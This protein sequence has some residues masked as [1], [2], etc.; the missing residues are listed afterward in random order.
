MPTCP[1]LSRR[2]RGAVS[3]V[4]RRCRTTASPPA[5]R[6]SRNAADS[7]APAPRRAGESAAVSADLHAREAH[8]A[9]VAIF[10][11]L[12]SYWIISFCGPR[13]IRSKFL[14]PVIV[15][16]A[17]QAVPNSMASY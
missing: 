11:I 12:P 9:G 1:G 14:V 10:Y 15:A 7:E 5:M 2:L 6:R 13:M 4:M 8:Q 3:S 17:R 16:A